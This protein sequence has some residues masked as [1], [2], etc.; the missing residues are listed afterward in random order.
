MLPAR[1]FRFRN[2]AFGAAG[3][4]LLEKWD[5]RARGIRPHM[6][7]FGERLMLGAGTVLARMARD[8][9]GRPRPR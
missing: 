1:V 6:E 5:V 9:R 3:Q 4:E 2:G 7:I 8:E